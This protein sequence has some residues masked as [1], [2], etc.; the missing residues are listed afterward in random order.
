MPFRV[1]PTKRDQ[2][3]SLI[4]RTGRPGK[5]MEADP[6]LEMKRLTGV[7]FAPAV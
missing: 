1:G 3:S 5:Q 4:D 6:V 2:Q 7:N